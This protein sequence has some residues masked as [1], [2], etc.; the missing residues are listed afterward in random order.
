MSCSK[1]NKCSVK[2]KI[3]CVYQP[4]VVLS[5]S[6]KRNDQVYKVVASENISPDFVRC[7]TGGNVYVSEKFDGT[8]CLINEY[9]GRPWLWARH[10]IK[11]NKPADKRFKAYQH[12]K[13]E[14]ILSNENDQ[15]YPEFEWD[16]E[17]DFKEAPDDWIPAS[18]L[19][20]AVPDDIGHMVGWVPVDPS[21]RQHLWHLSAVHFNDAIGLFLKDS[22]NVNEPMNIQVDKLENYYGKTFELIGSNVNG[23]PY[24]LGCKK[25][26]I[27]VLVQHGEFSVSE[28]PILE[29]S[30]SHSNLVEW[31]NEN[32][33]GNLEGI[34]WHT[35]DGK[36]F[37]LHRHHLD[38][39]WPVDNLRIFSRAVTIDMSKYEGMGG[40]RNTLLEK[41]KLLDRKLFDLITEISIEEIKNG[42]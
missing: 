6:C 5:K 10:D 20:K 18:G 34:V 39:K 3:K 35:V 25:S 33:N 16:V 36:M 29:N 21:L 8:C 17:N 31:F 40:N 23:N 7:T 26:P 12:K 19:E 38:L 42:Q 2:G 9:H 28:F 11:P 24:R 1:D 22:K 14:Y 30:L 13:N 27:H 4:N 41:L 37:K 15:K 32:T